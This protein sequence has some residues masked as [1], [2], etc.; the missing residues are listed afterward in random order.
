M[1]ANNDT[2]LTFRTSNLLLPSMIRSYTNC[3]DE[4]LDNYCVC[5]FAGSGAAPISIDVSFQYNMSNGRR[6]G[7]GSGGRNS[8]AHVKQNPTRRMCV[9]EWY[10]Y[11]A[12]F[13]VLEHFGYSFDFIKNVFSTLLLKFKR[14]DR[15]KLISLVSCPSKRASE[16]FTNQRRQANNH[17]K[18][19][20]NDNDKHPDSL[21]K[22]KL[23]NHPSS[24]YDD[25]T[26][27]AVRGSTVAYPVRARKFP[28]LVRSS[29]STYENAPQHRAVQFLD[30][31]GHHAVRMATNPFRHAIEQP[32][33][34]FLVGIA[35]EDGCF[36]SGLE[37]RF[38]VGHL[39][40]DNYRDNA[41]HY[42]SVAISASVTNKSDGPT[43]RSTS[44]NN[45]TFVS[46][47]P[48][49]GESHMNGDERVDL[50]QLGQN[51][52]DDDDSELSLPN[53]NEVVQG[54]SAPGIWHVYTCIFDHEKSVIRVNGCEESKLQH[55]D[56]ND[57]IGCGYGVLDGLT[58]GS[59]HKFDMSLCDGGG[60]EG[61][62]EGAIAEIAV[63][64]GHLP[65]DDVQKMENML[66]EKYGIMHNAEES[67]MLNEWR[68]HA[69]ALIM[70]PPRWDPA[71]HMTDD[72][73]AVDQECQGSNGIDD[74]DVIV[75]GRG[76]RTSSLFKKKIAPS[77][78]LRIAANHRNVAWSK[79]DPV[80]G[81][82]LSVSR[83][84]SKSTGSSDW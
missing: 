18:H 53:A 24:M 39:Y 22:W 3:P 16:S 40:P 13:D 15:E 36:L 54:I 31:P 26:T 44:S 74:G 47:D 64:K 57:N 6:G 65:L 4:T 51:D 21:L 52:D 56:G 49:I 35:C 46:D 84:G 82:K 12:P 50:Y 81:K 76:S 11:S 8:N 41:C 68:R 72:Y 79:R 48:S 23:D 29:F 7:N 33:T 9:K 62:G 80:T 67:L 17:N 59:D 43:N 1:I 27:C 66:L 77:I 69:H 19:S 58:I 5:W 63:Y 25:L 34:I 78:P 2:L 30:A 75:D 14:S 28:R 83:I 70:H 42:S 32:I 10:G 60:N 37:S 20:K 45:L 73:G 61:E 71:D 38:E 55:Y